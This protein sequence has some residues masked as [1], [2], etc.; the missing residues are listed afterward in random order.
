[1]W[2]PTPDSGLAI[3]IRFAPISGFDKPSS[4]LARPYRLCSQERPACLRQAGLLCPATGRSR[5]VFYYAF[6][7][8]CRSVAGGK[9]ANRLGG[10]QFL[11]IRP[12][13][14]V[15]VELVIIVE[16]LDFVEQVGIF[17]VD[18]PEFVLADQERFFA[19]FDRVFVGQGDIVLLVKHFDDEF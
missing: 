6:R 2:R 3:S 12:V 15:N 16:T 19:R 7:T 18:E 14:L 9:P 5:P 10:Q 4:I 17:V 11:V 13:L 8:I 1:M